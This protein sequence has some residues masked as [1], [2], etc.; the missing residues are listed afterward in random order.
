M[1]DELSPEDGELTNPEKRILDAIAWMEAIGIETPEQPAVAFLAGYRFGGGAYNNPRGRLRSKGFVEYVGGRIRLT[2]EGRG[3]VEP[4]DV[5]PTTTGLHAAVLA[6][7]PSPEQRVLQPLLDC[8]PEPMSNEEL[9]DAAS[10]T[11]N[12]GGYNNP[13]GRLRS[14][15]LV[16][17]PA[18]GQVRANDLLFP[19]GAPA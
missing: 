4:P 1:P 9:A 15:G 10:Y 7:L 19:E 18:P 3:L 16:E 5:S 12:T 17:Y 2:D 8:W 14:L 6:R 11:P 13:R